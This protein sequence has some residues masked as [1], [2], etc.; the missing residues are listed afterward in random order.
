MCWIPNQSCKCEIYEKHAYV[1][2][3]MKGTRN[4]KDS[5]N[6]FSSKTL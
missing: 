2:E 5:E 3:V 4:G 1:I 6:V